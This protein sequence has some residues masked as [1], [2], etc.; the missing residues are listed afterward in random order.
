MDV[1]DVNNQGSNLEEW[2]SDSVESLD[3]LV[4]NENTDESGDENNESGADN[5]GDEKKKSAEKT[6]T[7]EEVRRIAA[8]EKRNGASSVLNKFGLNETKLLELANEYK[9]E[10]RSKLTPEQVAEQIEAEANAKT[11]ESVMEVAMVKAEVMAIKLG[12]LPEFS[13]DVVALAVTKANREEVDVTDTDSLKTI[14]EELKEKHPAMFGT[15]KSKDED[16][17]KG[18]GK[19]PPRSKQNLQPKG[20]GAKLA[21]QRVSESKSQKGQ[22]LWG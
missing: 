17:D 8:K 9:A 18:T 22:S 1:N 6:Y 11:K 19:P 12:C 2:D 21:K 5:K 7:L 10:Q 15:E 3:G 16:D 14:V 13:E 4:D 20:L